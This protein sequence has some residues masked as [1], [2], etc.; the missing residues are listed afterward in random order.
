MI[1]FPAIDLRNGQVVRLSQGDYNQM[2]VYDS[3]PEAIAKG[4]IKAG[5]THLHTVDL[6]G[7][8]DGNPQ[9]RAVIKA[10]CSLGLFVQV[11]GGMRTA[12]DVENTL[13][14][15]AK[16]VIIGTMALTNFPLLT[17]LAKEHAG[18]IAVGVD[19]ANGYIATH[20]WK[21]V[22]DV[23]GISFCKRLCDIGI[24]TVIYTDIAKDGL[25]AGTNLAIYK[26]LSTIEGLQV[27]ASGG[28]SYEHE[29][30]ELANLN[31]YGAI[32]GKALYAGKLDLAT[33]LQLAKGGAPC[34]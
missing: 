13:A 11:G 9:N 27:V 19:T 28:I 18:K 21:Q 6:D 8:K 14:L 34:S 7:A 30:I 24:D 33:A 12:Q 32:L 29:I 25:L 3:D 23:S 22:S 10:L 15:G 1:L 5:A 31:T 20:G 4:F 17:S 26:E 2:T 16:R